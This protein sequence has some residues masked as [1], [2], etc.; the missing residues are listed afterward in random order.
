MIMINIY[1]HIYIYN[2][3]YIFLQFYL[4]F[5]KFASTISIDTSSIRINMNTFNT[6]Y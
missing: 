6:V 2:F 3:S 1:I 5:M 4:K